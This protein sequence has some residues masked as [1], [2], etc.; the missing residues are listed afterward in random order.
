MS[1]SE[2]E[3]LIRFKIEYRGSTIRCPVCGVEADV[4]G[5]EPV[6]WNA[7]SFCEYRTL[8]TAWIPVAA[9]HNPACRVSHEQSV[10][11]NTLL[12]ELMLQDTSESSNITP[13]RCFFNAVRP[14][15]GGSG[16]RDA[17]LKAA[18]M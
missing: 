13:L 4:I 17:D 7:A 11:A 6:V 1:F 15:E 9:A 10:L 16:T 8:V 14:G 18:R 3:S 5:K 12:L 2:R